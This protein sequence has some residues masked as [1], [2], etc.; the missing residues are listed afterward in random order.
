M[1]YVNE[2]HEDRTVDT[3][4]DFFFSRIAF[5]IDDA[6]KENGSAMVS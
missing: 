4:L 1:N 6:E 2:Y 3:S 5:A